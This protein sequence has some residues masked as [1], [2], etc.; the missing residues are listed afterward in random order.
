MRR[1]VYTGMRGITQR[2]T[3]DERNNPEVY[4]GSEEKRGVYPGSEE[5]RGVYPG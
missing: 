4:P 3:R 1:E 5:K 2:Y